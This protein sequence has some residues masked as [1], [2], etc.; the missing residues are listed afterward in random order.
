MMAHIWH[1]PD[2]VLFLSS[3]SMQYPTH[4]HFLFS[5][6]RAFDGTLNSDNVTFELNTRI[7]L[8]QGVIYQRAMYIMESKDL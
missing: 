3:L 5:L 2:R 4:T 6:L 1:H 7:P 8:Y